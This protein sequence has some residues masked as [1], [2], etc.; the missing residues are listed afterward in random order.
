M[1]LHNITRPSKQHKCH[2]QS[3]NTNQRTVI[4]FHYYWTLPVW[5]FRHICKI[6]TRI[7]IGW[8]PSVANRYY[9]LSPT[10]L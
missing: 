3:N 5:S 1:F 2:K 7:E 10:H 8:S 9:E 4:R 6:R